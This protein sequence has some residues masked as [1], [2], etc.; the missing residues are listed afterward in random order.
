MHS[1]IGCQ[2]TLKLQAPVRFPDQFSQLGLTS[3]PGVLLAGP[4]GCGK[5]LLAKVYLVTSHMTVSLVCDSHMTKCRVLH[6]LHT[7]KPIVQ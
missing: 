2:L 3:P 5:T 7:R 1:K 4:P 6:V